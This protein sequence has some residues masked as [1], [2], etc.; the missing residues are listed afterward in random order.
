MEARDSL[1]ADWQTLTTVVGN[2]QPVSAN[3]DTTGRTERY[4]R[5]VIP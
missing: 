5:I 2:G 1:T 3:D 4:Y